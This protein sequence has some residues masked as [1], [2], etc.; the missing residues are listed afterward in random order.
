MQDTIELAELLYK[1]DLKEWVSYVLSECTTLVRTESP[2]SS[3]HLPQSFEFNSFHILEAIN[4]HW[5]CRIYICGLIQT[6]STLAYLAFPFDISSIYDEEIQAATYIGMTI[7]Y[8]L[9]ITPPP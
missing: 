8:V 9:Q 5:A 6:L 4:R 2:E 3:I 1:T 7:Q